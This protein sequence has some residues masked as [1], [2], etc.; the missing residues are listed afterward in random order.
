MRRRSLKAWVYFTFRVPSVS[1]TAASAQHS[2]YTQP[3]KQYTVSRHRQARRSPRAPPAGGGTNERTYCHYILTGL[4]SR[5]ARTPWN[6]IAAATE[7][8]NIIG[9]EYC[10]S[11]D[12]CMPLDQ[13]A[14]SCC[15]CC[16]QCFHLDLE[17][18]TM[19]LDQWVL[20]VFWQGKAFFVMQIQ[21]P[22]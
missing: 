17:R 12:A 7:S 3:L 20:S 11:D 18:S 9:L 15:L 10:H 14:V 16:M 19:P 1:R 13:S 6:A 8:R 5:V 4:W 2:K 22:I 21:R